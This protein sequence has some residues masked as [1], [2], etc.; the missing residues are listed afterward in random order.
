[1]VEES[2][3]RRQLASVKVILTGRLHIPL[4]LDWGFIVWI[5]SREAVESRL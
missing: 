3:W 5:S 1:M 4:K 2:E